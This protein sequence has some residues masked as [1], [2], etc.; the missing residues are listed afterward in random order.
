MKQWFAI[1]FMMGVVLLH[2]CGYTVRMVALEEEQQELQEKKSLEGDVARLRLDLKKLRKQSRQAAIVLKKEIERNESLLQASLKESRKDILGLQK[3]QAGLNV[4]MDEAALHL[5]MVQGAVEEKDRQLSGL[6]HQIENVAFRVNEHEETKEKLSKQG[7][8]HES[9]LQAQV[10]VVD[11]LKRR[12]DVQKKRVASLKGS[13][14]AQVDAI[15]L[16]DSN[17]RAVSKEQEKSLQ[18]VSDQ[19]SELA[20]KIPPALNLQSVR[21]DELEWQVKKIKSE[22]DVKQIDKDLAAFSSTLDALRKTLDLLGSRITAKVD[23]QGRLIRATTKKVKGIEARLTLGDRPAS[24]SSK[25][26]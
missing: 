1:F 3:G 19:A 6:S 10:K 18:G 2:G 16:I 24:L 26:K 17:L 22:I 15:N 8:K 4:R 5:R 13:L 23:E 14:Q 7:K 21:L 9:L 11:V 25:A 20:E 12:L